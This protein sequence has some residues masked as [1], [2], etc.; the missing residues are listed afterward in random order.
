MHVHSLFCT[1]RIPECVVQSP[2]ALFVS[3]LVHFCPYV[4]RKCSI[5][6]CKGPSFYSA[7]LVCVHSSGGLSLALADFNGTYGIT[8]VVEFLYQL[9]SNYSSPGLHFPCKGVLNF[10]QAQ[11]VPRAYSQRT[12]ILHVYDWEVVWFCA[13]LSMMRSESGVDNVIIFVW[14]Y[15]VILRAVNA[16]AY[17][18]SIL[19]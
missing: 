13:C 4:W 19:D 6:R 12:V 2:T 11:I 14:S 18:K 10:F 7:G 9:L 17:M 5:S 15:I 3:K 1:I 16:T 8:T